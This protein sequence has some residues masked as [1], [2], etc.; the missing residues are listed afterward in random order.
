MA[1]SR[2]HVA[3]YAARLLAE[4]ASTQKVANI[5]A[6]YIIDRKQQRLIEPLL[7]EIERYL[8]L[9][10][11]QQTIHA[12]TAH[13][14]TAQ[15]RQDII[16]SFKAKKQ[17]QIEH[18]IEPSLLGGITIETAG[19]RYDASLKTRIQKLKMIDSQT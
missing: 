6:S 18:T 5:L 2:R 10:Y 13:E 12:A 14:L 11:D 4:G 8:Y 3:Q 1:L 15:L 17:I 16:E 9:D 7:Q 19:K